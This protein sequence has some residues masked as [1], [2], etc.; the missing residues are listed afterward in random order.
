M[1][2]RKVKPIISTSSLMGEI[3]SAMHT[4]AEENLL[5]DPNNASRI[6]TLNTYY[7][8]TLD[9]HLAQEDK[10]FLYATGKNTAIKWIKKRAIQVT[11]LS[12]NLSVNESCGNIMSERSDKCDVA[13]NESIK[14]NTLKQSEDHVPEVA[15]VQ[16]SDE[17]RAE[18]SSDVRLNES[19][20]PSQATQRYS[21]APLD[22]DTKDCQNPIQS[23]FGPQ[24]S[25][26]ISKYDVTSEPYGRDS[27]ELVQKQVSEKTSKSQEGKGNNDPPETGDDILANSRIDPPAETGWLNAEKKKNE[28]PSE[29]EQPAIDPK[30]KAI[31][32]ALEKGETFL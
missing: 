26:G 14:Q 18:L 3:L 30:I 16:W 5:R 32:V 1:K 11:Q 13:E 23:L 6:C 31:T 7:V 12:S 10:D 2:N 21:K 15:S 25:I 8:E 27:M 9:L 28:G 19:S 24:L 29:K 17:V 4:V 22:P 20:V